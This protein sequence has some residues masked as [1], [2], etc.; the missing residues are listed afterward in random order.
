MNKQTLTAPRFGR[1]SFS[2]M[3]LAFGLLI[4]VSYTV[5]FVR[6]PV[7]VYGGRNIRTLSYDSLGGAFLGCVISALAVGVFVRTKRMDPTQLASS[8]SW[9]HWF[10]FFV[11]LFL[12]L[13]MGIKDGNFARIQIQGVIAALFGI[14]WS[15]AA[16]RRERSRLW[17]FYSAV[18]V[19][20]Y[21][22]LVTVASWFME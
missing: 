15:I 12:V 20:L 10:L 6:F 13:P 7:T 1:Y 21:P 2:A 8:C 22:S 11:L 9:P 14:R 18:A 3:L 16:F 4:L 19:L 5:E 17:I